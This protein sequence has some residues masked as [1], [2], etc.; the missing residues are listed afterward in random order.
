MKLRLRGLPALLPADGN[1]SEL[2]PKDA[3]LL[4]L[5]ALDGPLTRQ[6]LAAWLWP[7]KS[8][9]RQLDSLRQRLMRLDARGPRPLFDRRGAALAL[10][11]DLLHDLQPVP[12]DDGAEPDTTDAPLLGSLRFDDSPELAQWVDQARQRLRRQ[13]R[14]AWTG[15]AEALEQQRRVA[16]ALPWALR[17][18]DD[19]PLHEHAQRRV[20]RLHYLRGDRS[21]A[22]ALYARLQQRL[23][24]EL[25]SA[26]AD[27]TRE[28][29][30]MIERSDPHAVT[31]P[32][33][34]T[35]AAPA[36]DAEQLAL[37]RRPVERVQRQQ[38]W[39]QLEQ[40]WAEGRSSLI[41]GEAGIGKTRLLDDFAQAMQVPLRLG[42]RP[43]DARVPYAL[44]G[45]LLRARAAAAQ[46]LDAATRAELARIEPALGTAAGGPIVPWRLA[47]AVAALLDDVPALAIDDLHHADDASL[48]LLPL[49]LEAP[50]RA[51]LAV[52][53]D[54]MPAGVADWLRDD[55]ALQSITLAPLSPDGVALLLAG[56]K[57][58]GAPGPAG[59][60]ALWRHTGGNPYFVLETLRALLR[61]G[62]TALTAGPLPVTEP[63]QRLIS[64]R[65]DSLE[66]TARA[67]AGVAA[68]AGGDFDAALAAHALGLPLAGVLDPWR[69][70]QAAQLVNERGFVHD[71]VGE[72]VRAALPPPLAAGLHA[73]I[74]EH[75]DSLDA[76]PARRAAHWAAAGRPD[77]AAPA[78]AAAARAADAASRKAEEQQHWAAAAEA[79]QQ[80]GQADAAFE[81][82]VALAQARLLGGAIDEGLHLAL[83]L[84]QAAQGDAQ[85]ALTARTLSHAHIQSSAWQDGLDQA[86]Q[87]V[88]AARRAALSDLEID[89]TLLAATAASQ[90][91]RLADSLA[92]VDRAERLAGGRRRDKT[93]LGLLEMKGYVLDRVGRYAEAA[94]ACGQ[95][96]DMALALDEQNELMTLYSSRAS[97]LGKL[98]R[99]PEALADA[100]Q[101]AEVGRRIGQLSGYQAQIVA[102]HRGLFGALCGRFDGA[103]DDLERAVAGLAALG[104]EPARVLAEHQL[105]WVWTVLGQVARAQRI[106]SAPLDGLPRMQAAR[107]LSL[108]AR[109]VRLCGGTPVAWP[110]GW[111]D[112][113]VEPPVALSA[114]LDQARA[115]PPEQ[116]LALCEAVAQESLALSLAS[117]W[118]N[119]R[120]GRVDAL[121]QLDP[122]RAG[123]EARALWQDLQGYQP[124]DAWWP[125]VLHVLQ[126][127]LR[128]AGDVA[129]ADALVDRAVAW[130]HAARATLPAPFHASFVG[131]NRVNAALLQAWAGRAG[132]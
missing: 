105:A 15:R 45:R 131:R 5:L 125:E 85:V 31:G 44:L 52:R 47:R 127:A 112:A 11:P 9:P 103:V 12:D 33:P 89:V 60:E 63:V 122:S 90:L 6:Q 62:G 48:E 109:L 14:Q 119:G 71:L 65:L 97:V 35:P 25:G 24:Q 30:A 106:V 70:L 76:P 18:A 59:A 88:E 118:F 43:G 107:R 78:H 49:L 91:G 51:V 57:L 84:R 37:L 123:A 38:P 98:A 108:R 56:L 79:Y 92:W 39:R 93:L 4:A 53:P 29:A 99:L 23:Q 94:V 26:P 2:A 28:L 73:R 21:A 126:Q 120:V 27:E 61:D 95:A 75:L 54:S 41:V 3:A 13:Q 58:P 113:H 74:A 129:A 69:A 77:R 67:L 17:L 115:A 64:Q 10:A 101:A 102:L 32:D 83:A 68:L 117:G 114:R 46:A 55:P 116:A 19:E 1:P 121:R 8:G 110:E 36:A 40:A 96:I 128:G 22:L 34:A 111:L 66:P 87:A 16:E 82:R 50:R 7:D 81:A 124:T 72:S 80:A 20:M 86:L 104:L 100:Q 42:A 132:T 130:L